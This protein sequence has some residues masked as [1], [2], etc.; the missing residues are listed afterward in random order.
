MV[1]SEERKTRMH[2]LI[3]LLNDARHKYY[4]GEEDESA[5]TD[6]QYNAY[7]YELETLEAGTG[8]RLAGSPTGMVGY[9][10]PEGKIEHEIPVLSLKSTKNVDDLLHFLGEENGVLSYKLDGMSIVLYY[11]EEGKLVR[12]VSRGDGRLGKDI[13]KNAILMQNVLRELPFKHRMILRGEGCISL[14]TFDFIQRVSDWEGYKNPR[15]MA[16]G[17]LNRSKTRGLLLKELIFIPHT[18]MFLDDH[19]PINKT[20]HAQLEYLQVL[21]FEVVRRS[22]V[23]NFELLEAIERYSSAVETYAYPVDGLVLTIDSVKHGEALGS[24]N[25]FPRHSMAFKWADES[26]LTKV[27]GMKWSVSDAGY[28]TPVVI[29]EP[30][31]IDG[32]T[33]KQA[34]LHNLKKFK[35]LA[36]GIGDTIKVYKANKII[37]EVEENL[38]RSGTE[39]YPMMCPVCNQP[40][41]SVATNVTQ[42]LYCWHCQEKLKG[43]Y[44]VQN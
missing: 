19:S 31:E 22:F 12:A 35:D 10:E 30:V 18:V 5:L 44:D 28:I 7:L 13:T 32:T 40:T 11:N 16:A 1:V 37:P 15:N 34:S 26:V 29:F 17:L 25:S 39:K 4:S 21:G 3:D 2:Y 8:I 33:V 42:K 27:T 9:E 6:K 24:T 38:T 41:Y 23:R 43:R 20:R 14:E 36:I